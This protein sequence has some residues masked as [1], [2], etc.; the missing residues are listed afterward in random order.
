MALVLRAGLGSM[1]W[2]VLTQGL[3]RHVPL[4]FGTITALTGV[5]VLL[6]WI[7]LRQRP[8]VGTVANVV[9]ISAAIDP[10]IALLALLPDPLPWSVRGVLLLA[11]VGLNAL[12]TSLYVG[13]GLGP[14]PRDGLMT[15]LVARTGWSIRLVRTGIEVTVVAAGWLLGG[16]VGPGTVLYA[17][18]VGPLVHLWLPRLAV[19][20]IR[21]GTRPGRPAASEGA[22]DAAGAHATPRTSGSLAEPGPGRTSP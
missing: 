11:G 19:P 9:V 14:G 5:L 16:Q 21:T 8:G 22:A 6:C 17:L 3:V 18:A 15:G 12:A 20:A 13:A 10:A 1:P 4:S 2:D 7:P